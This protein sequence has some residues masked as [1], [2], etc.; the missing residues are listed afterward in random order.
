ML[1]A[2]RE[3]GSRTYRGTHEALI[4]LA[5]LVGI[6]TSGCSWLP[7]PS[8]PSTTVWG[9]LTGSPTLLCQSLLPLHHWRTDHS[10][11][12]QEHGPWTRLW[13]CLHGCMHDPGR[14][15]LSA[16]LCFFTAPHPGC[17]QGSEQEMDTHTLQH[18]GHPEDSLW[19]ALLFLL[20]LR[21]QFWVVSLGAVYLTSVSL[22]FPICKVEIKQV[23][24]SRGC[25]EDEVRP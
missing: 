18:A 20:L 4:A 10:C 17:P 7:P 25:V 24:A 14:H 1:S 3:T 21:S 19:Q 16:G 5:V 15:C 11:A 2:S 9:P 8:M 6:S 23:P 13:P 22:S 12:L